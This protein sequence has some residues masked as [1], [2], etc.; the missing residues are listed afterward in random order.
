MTIMLRN[1]KLIII[2]CVAV[3]RCHTRTVMFGIPEMRGGGFAL[4]YWLEVWGESVYC[5]M[6]THVAPQSSTW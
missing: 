6:L 2:V 5:T 1:R 4:F 3:A